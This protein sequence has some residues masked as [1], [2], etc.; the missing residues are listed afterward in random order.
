MV[1]HAE[2]I[3]TFLSMM[4]IAITTMVTMSSGRCESDDLV[5]VVSMSVHGAY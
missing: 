2:V 1:S 4:T 5:L 3:I